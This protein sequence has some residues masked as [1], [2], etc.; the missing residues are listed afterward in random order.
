[1]RD[2]I[3]CAM[4][5]HKGID[6]RLGQGGQRIGEIIEVEKTEIMLEE[7]GIKAIRDEVASEAHVAAGLA[8]QPNNIVWIRSDCFLVVGEDRDLEGALVEEFEQMLGV[9][10]YPASRIVGRNPSEAELSSHDRPVVEVLHELVHS[11]RSVAP[12]KPQRVSLPL[13]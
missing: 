8:P 7:C 13:R 9:G 11:R 6:T 12:P 10:G 3:L 5:C 2:H 4:K 1:M